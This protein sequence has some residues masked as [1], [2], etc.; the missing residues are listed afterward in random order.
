MVLFEHKLQKLK[1]MKQF[2]IHNSQFTI[3][4]PFT[5]IH[6]AQWPMANGKYL[7]NGKGLMVNGAS[8]GGV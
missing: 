7:V 6:E 4:Y 5:V 1:N 3:H 8:K 2:T